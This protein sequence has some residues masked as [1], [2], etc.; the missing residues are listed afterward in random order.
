MRDE[1]AVI[2]AFESFFKENYSFFYFTAYHLLSDEELSRDMVSECTQLVWERY[3]QGSVDEWKAYMY[4]TVRNKCLDHLRREQVK[5]KYIDFYKAVTSESFEQYNEDDERLDAIYHSIETLP[6]LP[7]K[8]LEMCYFQKMKYRDVADELNISTSYV[9]KLI[10]AAL[11][12]IRKE[13][14]S[15][16]NSNFI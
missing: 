12:H 16:N 9:K 7:R 13:V 15:N 5:K 14:L 4:H 6:E 3:R 11:S 8:V 10:M 1:K 2:K